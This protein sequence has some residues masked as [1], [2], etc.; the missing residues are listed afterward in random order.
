MCFEASSC[1]EVS[2][3]TIDNLLQKEAEVTWQ[4]R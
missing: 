4:V 3:E 2:M 1:R